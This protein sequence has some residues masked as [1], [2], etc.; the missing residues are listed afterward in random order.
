MRPDG[1]LKCATMVHNA[2]MTVNDALRD[3]AHLL[4]PKK[5]V[6]AADKSLGRLEAE[7]LLGYA[8]KK[9]KVWLLTH[10]N[11]ELRTTRQRLFDSHIR[12]RLKHEPIAYILGK[13]EFYGRRFVVTKDTL[14]PRPETE[15]I[16]DLVVGAGFPRPG[17]HAEG[18]GDRAPTVWD[19]GTGSGAIAVTL[20]KQY[21]TI[22][23]L[24]TDVSIKT[25][26]VA[27][28]NARLLRAKNV[29]FLK[30]DLLQPAAYRWLAKNAKGKHL[31]ICANLPYL[32]TSDIK[33]LD[34]DVVKYEPT[35][36][37]FSGKDGLDLISRFLGQLSRHLDEWDY[38]SST[39][40]V[41]FDPPQTAT[42]KRIAKK[43]FPSSTVTIHKDLAGRNRVL[44]I[45]SAL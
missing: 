37:L 24:A 4:Q 30:S 13:K 16:I 27:R 6:C 31:T 9:D 32:P 14:I 42:L 40:L 8:M 26:A 10:P 5:V 34:A 23:I 19:V 38:A 7:I 15:M 33:K 36:A 43:L 35:R 18:R 41:E 21:P 11:S 39:I 3:A 25:L 22:K 17:R 44:K 1:L 28:K 20:A 12:R 2:S 29:T 45:M